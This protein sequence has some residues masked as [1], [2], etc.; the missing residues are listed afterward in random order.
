MKRVREIVLCHVE[1]S[2]TSLALP[3][4]PERRAFGRGPQGIQRSTSRRQG[5]DDNRRRRDGYVA[6]KILS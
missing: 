6:R 3:C 5:S 1:R 4:V 2:E